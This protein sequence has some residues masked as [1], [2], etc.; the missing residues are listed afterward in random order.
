MTENTSLLYEQQYRKYN[1]RKYV[2]IYLWWYWLPAVSCAVSCLLLLLPF[3]LYIYRQNRVFRKTL[4]KHFV[5]GSFF[6][7]FIF[8]LMNLMKFKY[9]PFVNILVFFLVY[10]S[11][12]HGSSYAC[13]HCICENISAPNLKYW[14]I[15]IYFI[16]KFLHIFVNG[17][18]R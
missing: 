12:K 2:C 7:L 14:T 18:K 5:F 15:K 10:W 13:Y 17:M 6:F 16:S 8:V 1:T 11:M 4:S 9:F 3:P